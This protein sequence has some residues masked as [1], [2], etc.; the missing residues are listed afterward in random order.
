MCQNAI[1]RSVH[2]CGCSSPDWNQEEAKVIN[3]NEFPLEPSNPVYSIILLC[4]I[5]IQSS[6]CKSPEIQFRQE[7]STYN[8]SKINEDWGGEWR[9]L[10]C[11]WLLTLSE[12]GMK[13][14][15]QMPSRREGK[16][17]RDRWTLSLE[18]L[19]PCIVLQIFLWLE[20]ANELLPMCHFWNWQGH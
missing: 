13:C 9:L 1:W 3:V 4:I 12:L 6:N 15:R 18:N 11:F 14:I 17:L 16:D 20:G 8:K 5:V 10:L 2:V 7:G 19:E